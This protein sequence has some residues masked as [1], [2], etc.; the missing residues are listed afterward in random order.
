MTTSCGTASPDHA[1]APAASEQAVL[2][3][4]ADAA[5]SV[6]FANPPFEQFTGLSERNLAGG[7]WLDAV[8]PDDAPGAEAAWR[9]AVETAESYQADLRL[10]GADGD[11]RWFRVRGARRRSDA[12]HDPWVVT[13]SPRDARRDAAAR[14]QARLDPLIRSGLIGIGWGHAS[15]RIAEVN[16]AFL[17]MIGQTREAFAADGIDWRALTAPEYADRDETALGELSSAGVCRPYEKEYVLPGRRLPILIAMAAVD[18]PDEVIDHVAVVIDLSRQAQARST[19]SDLVEAAETK[20]AVRSAELRRAEARLTHEVQ[21][22][23]TMQ[24]AM[25]QN[26]KLE[27]LG[28]L[29]AGVAHD[30]NN[31]LAAI[32]ASLTLIG[33][34]SS[35]ARIRALAEEG[36]K[37]ADKGAGLVGQLLA[38]TRRQAAEAGRCDLGPL[39]ADLEPQLRQILGPGVALTIDTAETPPALAIDPTQLYSA[40]VNLAVNAR[41]AMPS[42]GALTLRVE[43]V[44]EDAEDRPAGMK[45]APAVAIHIRDS[46]E[47]M[48]PA[49]LQRALEPFFTTKPPGKGTGLG[50]SMV[51]ALMLQVGGAFRIRSRLDEGTTVSLYVPLAETAA[52]SGNAA[53][54][55][56]ADQARADDDAAITRVMRRL[57]A[58]AL[59]E[60]L[61]IWMS[62]RGAARLPTAAGLRL[63]PRHEPGVARVE[64]DQ[65]RVPIGFRVAS[66]GADLAARLSGD[67]SGGTL[68]VVGDQ[69]ESTWEG[70]YRRCVKSGRPTYEMARFGFGAGDPLVFERLLL[71]CSS[72]GVTVDALIAAVEFSGGET[73]SAEPP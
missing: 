37:A 12:I 34:Q 18:H 19:L 17:E 20:L 7:A 29:T 22:R 38:F 58:P 44:A 32:L 25:V 70:L 14:A 51:N 57:R 52:V 49:V 8:H 36:A 66:V 61:A 45:G 42:G 6:T 55:R 62:A 35:E 54:A 28:Q 9:Q 1:P 33:R 56:D 4:V 68:D 67:P 47:G 63:E 40:I 53:A 48:P 15:G 23:E 72:D 73:D 65:T 26:Q 64:V 27:A 59:V 71:P 2:V 21:R 41:D 50:L 10:R 24:S 16:D 31:V 43:A 5:G 30:F 69:T 39:L 60:L 11:H 3:F 13:W 46:G